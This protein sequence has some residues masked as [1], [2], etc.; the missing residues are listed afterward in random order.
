MLEKRFATLCENILHGLWEMDPATATYLGVHNYDGLLPRTSAPAL[1]AYGGQL[2]HF[3]SLLEEFEQRRD[4]LGPESRDDLDLIK[5]QIITTRYHDLQSESWLRNPA[6]YTE[7]LLYGLYLLTIREYLSPA[8]RINSLL[9]RMKEC[10][11]F[12]SEAA[13]NLADPSRIPGIWAETAM[14]QLAAGEHFILQLREKL[15]KED[16]AR[17]TEIDSAAGL[18]QKSLA[19]FSTFISEMLPSCQGDFACGPEAFDLLLT[20][21]HM[22]DTPRTELEQY[23]REMIEETQA[24]MKEVAAE[25]RAGADI[26]EVIDEITSDHPAPDRVVEAYDE[27]M[28]QARDFVSKK[29]IAPIPEGQEL[30]VEATPE[31]QRSTVPYAAYVPPAVMAGKKGG[32]FWVTP[33]D[34]SAEPEALQR[35]LRDHCK[36]GLPITALHEGFPGHHLQFCHVAG[37]RPPVRRQYMTSV[38]VE[39][40]ALYCEE[41]MIR[42]G[43]ASSPE[44]KLMQLKDQ[45]WRA[46]RV[47]IDIGLHCNGM[48]AEEAVNMLVKTAGLERQNATAEVRRYTAT[49]TQPMSY[50]V[51][52]RE[53][54]RLSHWWFSKQPESSLHDFHQHLLSQGSIPFKL[55]RNSLLRTLHQS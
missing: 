28:Q 25:I 55:I 52:K 48:P 3:L 33:P 26:S 1:K 40:W 24:R 31:F 30:R 27:A 45:L 2:E 46:C 18:A 29:R 8:M 51:G 14:Q 10:G 36:A 44:T 41:M 21:H 23:G 35:Q 22:L 47:V 11:R 50:L 13:A 38:F 53:M 15:T 49:P 34:L 12:F 42:E 7:N 19:G 17:K 5:A 43:F 37:I 54:Q 16:P 39:G 32:L 9:S 4:E 6:R 20:Q